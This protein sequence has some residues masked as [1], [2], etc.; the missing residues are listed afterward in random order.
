M[1]RAKAELGLLRVALHG[2][3][4]FLG[5]LLWLA[6]RSAAAG[7]LLLQV[8]S[9]VSCTRLQTRPDK[10]WVLLREVRGSHDVCGL[11]LEPAR[12]RLQPD[13]EALRGR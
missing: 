10:Q 7:G 8:L 3:V 1:T 11:L 12:K 2:D 9:G 13:G 4:G 5:P 6:S